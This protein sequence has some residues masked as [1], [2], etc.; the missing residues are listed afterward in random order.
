MATCFGV[1]IY[2]I[3]RPADI[4]VDDGVYNCVI[5]IYTH[6][7]MDY[8]SVNLKPITPILISQNVF[9]SMELIKPPLST[10]PPVEHLLNVPSLL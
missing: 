1:F 6:S 8:T 10:L 7:W 9:R 5:Y 2:A 3:I 4:G